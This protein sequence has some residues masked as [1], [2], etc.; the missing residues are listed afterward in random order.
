MFDTGIFSRD[1]AGI[2]RQSPLILNIT[3]YV[4][5]NFSANALLAVGAS[6]LMSKESEEVEELVNSANALVINIGCLETSD[7]EAM[8]RAACISHTNGKPWVIDPVG[9][10]LSRLR[11]ETTLRLIRKYRPS[12]I[13]GNASEIRFLAG[14]SSIQKGVDSSFDST[15]AVEHAASLALETGAVISVSGAV[16]YITDGTDIIEIRNGSPMMS[17]VTAMGCTATA[18][19]GAFLAVDQ[20]PMQAAA[21]AMA[22]MGIAGEYAE[23]V[24]SGPGSFAAAFIDCLDALN[25]DNISEN[26]DYEQRTI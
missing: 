20:D 19:T 5:M 11:A 10:G 8:E 2:R 13:R 9:V 18:L 7:L 24:S 25:S 14:D 16:D 3:N 1:C 23:K 26:I 15:E 22:F 4:A 6:P 12:V 21:G 17:K